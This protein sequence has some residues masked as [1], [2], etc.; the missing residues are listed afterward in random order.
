MPETLIETDVVVIG[1]GPGGYA[2]AFAAADRG[3]HV[4]LVDADPQPGG[5]CLNRG[6]IPSKALLHVAKLIHEARGAKAWGIAFQEPRIDLDKLRSW[7]QSVVNKNAGGI[8]QLAKARGVELIQAWAQFEDERTLGLSS[9][10]GGPFDLGHLR[11]DR[12]IIAVGSRP[13][14]IP[15]LQLDSPRVMDST[16]A[17]ELPD[18]PAALLVIGGGYIGLE[19]STVYGALG[20]KVTVVEM[21]DGLL[22]GADRDLVKVLQKRLEATFAS[23]LLKTKVTAMHDRGDGIEV[24]LED[25]AGKAS[26]RSFDRVLTAIG[27]TPNSDGLGLE[28]TNVKLTERRFIEIDAQQRTNDPNIYAIGDV[29]GEPMLAH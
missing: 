2:G 24:E 25:G 12:A 29:A 19:M 16:A 22:P 18:V 15:A 9:G 20:S 27:R 26:E 7:K 28:N 21:T 6:C 14:V 23:I 1:A 5:V 10:R 4:V 17:L 13:T 8:R 11:F 3:L